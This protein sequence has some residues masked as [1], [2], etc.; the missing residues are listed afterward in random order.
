MW[1]HGVMVKHLSGFYKADGVAVTAEPGNRT[2]VRFH[3]SSCHITN[4]FDVSSCHMTN[5]FDVSHPF[6]MVPLVNNAALLQGTICI[7]YH[8]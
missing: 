2:H 8:F 4:D 1:P 6:L 3:V 5:D 7:F